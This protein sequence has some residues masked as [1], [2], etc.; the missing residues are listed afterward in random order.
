MLVG[1]HTTAQSA[2]IQSFGVHLSMWLSVGKEGMRGHAHPGAMRRKFFFCGTGLPT[3]MRKNQPLVPRSNIAGSWTLGGGLRVGSGLR[4]LC[5][6][7]DMPRR[8]HKHR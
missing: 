8:L 5:S 1:R 2:E 3:V 7:R 6:T 4:Y